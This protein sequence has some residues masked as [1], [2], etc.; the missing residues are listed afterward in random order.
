MSATHTS[1]EPNNT[2]NVE[3]D[4]KQ[5]KVVHV[6]N[7]PISHQLQVK[8]LLMIVLSYQINSILGDIVT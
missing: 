4:D 6:Q 1:P 7:S 8:N 3:E 5:T 2:T